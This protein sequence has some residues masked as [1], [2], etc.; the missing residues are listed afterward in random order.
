MIP[1]PRLVRG[2]LGPLTA[3]GSALA[4][5]AVAAAATPALDPP[6]VAASASANSILKRLPASAEELT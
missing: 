1:S 5:Q 3:I 2:L 6:P 4:L